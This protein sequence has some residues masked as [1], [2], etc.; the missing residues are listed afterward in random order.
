[1]AKEMVYFTKTKEI[2]SIIINYSKLS[3]KFVSQIAPLIEDISKQLK[4]DL[5][6]ASEE[7]VEVYIYASEM[8]ALFRKNC[9]L[10]LN[11]RENMSSK[12][13]RNVITTADDKI[14]VYL[15]GGLDTTSL[16]K[17]LAIQIFSRYGFEDLKKEQNVKSA[18]VEVIKNKNNKEQEEEESLEEEKLE[19]IDEQES[20]TIEEIDNIIEKKEVEL[21]LWLISGWYKYKKNYMNHSRSEDLGTYLKQRKIMKPENL[22]KSQNVFKEDNRLNALEATKVEYIIKTYGIKKLLK[23]FENPDIKEV[24]KTNKKDFDDNWKKY[25]K[26]EYVNK[27]MEQLDKKK[28][29]KEKN[30]IIGEEKIRL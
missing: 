12:L 3:E 2:K 26:E 13:S 27:T 18:T 16:A 14:H 4:I 30:Q 10:E 19:I 6:K 28:I 15:G 5:N 29:T 7:K 17:L 23:F 21:P 24:F 1:M 25:I 11:A 9:A 20:D 8:K 22:S